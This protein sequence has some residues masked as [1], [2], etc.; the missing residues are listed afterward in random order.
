MLD[1]AWDAYCVRASAAASMCRKR[2]DIR[3]IIYVILLRS[4]RGACTPLGISMQRHTAVSYMQPH[5]GLV[6]QTEFAPGARRATARPPSDFPLAPLAHCKER[7]Q[8]LPARRFGPSRMPMLSPPRLSPLIQHFSCESRPNLSFAD[9][10]IPIPRLQSLPWDSPPGHHLA[11]TGGTNTQTSPSI[12]K[13]PYPR[14][15][16]IPPSTKMPICFRYLLREKYP[17][18]A[19]RA[20]DG[21]ERGVRTLFG[22]HYYSRISWLLAQT[23]AA[24]AP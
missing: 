24:V 21:W 9:S 19:T 1:F 20:V 16:T 18:G 5:D 2:A 15:E 6:V 4:L 23:V 13:R 7:L 12:R 22:D 8:C 10:L 17:P 11:G 3:R 14:N